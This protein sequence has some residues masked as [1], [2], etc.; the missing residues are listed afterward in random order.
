MLCA[1]LFVVANTFSSQQLV[2]WDAFSKKYSIAD[3]YIMEEEVISPEKQRKRERRH[4]AAMEARERKE[5]MEKALEQNKAVQRQQLEQLRGQGEMWPAYEQYDVQNYIAPKIIQQTPQKQRAQVQF[6]EW[7]LPEKNRVNFV[8]RIVEVKPAPGSFASLMKERLLNRSVKDTSIKLFN[9]FISVI[10]LACEK[11]A[12]QWYLFADLYCL[13]RYNPEARYTLSHQFL[14]RALL[15][16]VQCRTCGIEPDKQC[17]KAHVVRLQAPRDPKKDESNMTYAEIFEK[18]KGQSLVADSIDDIRRDLHAENLG[19]YVTDEMID[20]CAI[21][22]AR[23]VK[24]EEYLAEAGSMLRYSF[25]KMR[26]LNP[27]YI[28]CKDK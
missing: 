25:G 20:T 1:L 16:I 4:H 9:D 22:F 10:V 7:L 13:L 15:G 2:D 27:L 19:D 18:R 24:N 17:R 23:F 11:D 12:N 26:E 5:A 8:R 14:I 28:Q 6:Q 3:D 21:Y